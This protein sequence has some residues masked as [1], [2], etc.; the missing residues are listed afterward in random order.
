MLYLL[1]HII[2]IIYALFIEQHS[3]IEL[4]NDRISCQHTPMVTPLK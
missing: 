2:V 3:V 1:S 4:R